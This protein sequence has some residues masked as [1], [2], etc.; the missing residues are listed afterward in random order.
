MLTIRAAHWP[1]DEAVLSALD[2]SFVTR[3]IYKPVRDEFSF[4]LIQKTVDSPLRKRY[5]LPFADPLER[6][7]WDYTAIAEENGEL[8]GFAAAQYAA[9]NRRA[10]IWHLYVVPAARQKGVGTKLLSTLDTY[11]GSVGARCLWLETQNVNYP[12]IQFYRRSGFQFCGFDESLY[13]PES[14]ADQEV[15]LF[16]VRPIAPRAR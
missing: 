7:S 12:A 9:W 1:Q 5:E 15:A 14:S 13:D 11:A 3:L 2:T 16:F 8:A 6:H 10:I 4:A